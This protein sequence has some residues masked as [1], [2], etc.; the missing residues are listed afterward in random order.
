[1]MPR[2]LLLAAAGITGGCAVGPDYVTPDPDAATD[3][4]IA[5]PR[6]EAAAPVADWWQAFDDPELNTLIAT[7]LVESPDLAAARAR[8]D[9]AR[10]V[11]GV[12][13]SAFWPSLAVAATYT[14]FE[15]SLESP[16]AFGQLAR[17]GL[18]ER[19]GEFW[20]ETLE[21]AWEIDAFGRI[22]RQNQQAAA[23]LGVAVADYRAAVLGIAAETA[24]AYFELR[25]AETRLAALQ[26]NVELSRSTLELTESK[27][28]VGLARRIDALR[29]EAEFAAASAA[30][31][32]LEAARD[33][34]LYRLGVLTGRTPAAMRDVLTARELP[35]PV[36]SIAIG[37]PADL[38]KRRPDVQA[39]ERRLAEA[40]A[41]VGVA[42]AAFFPQLTL[43]VNYGFEAVSAGDLGS[44]D[45]RTIGI[46]P[47]LRL[48][49]FEGGRLRRQL[50]AANAGA[51]AAAASYESAVLTAIAE[52]ESAIRRYNAS[53]VSAEQL[54]TAATAARDSATTARRLYDA[55]LIEFLEVLDAERRETELDDQ[56]AVARANALLAVTDLYRALGGGWEVASP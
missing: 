36:A 3:G 25:G 7:A 4:F 31:P 33:A 50:A 1:M 17:A 56:A 49:L 28:R 8:L 52:T 44:S 10:A 26:R 53:L 19:D 16:G 27:R 45:A 5:A 30:V 6:T 55:G 15:Q 41:G 9:Q 24:A 35:L 54:A 22:R 42:T 47:G 39:A 48:P 37:T 34:S 18:A 23:S 2:I 20:N 29:A 32:G 43:G 12:A 40:T 46:V 11:R 14:N 13:R 51:E 38:L 21:T